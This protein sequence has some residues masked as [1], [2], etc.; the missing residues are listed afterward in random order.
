MRL[1][2]VY[3]RH[4]HR[5]PHQLSTVD[6]A[7]APSLDLFVLTIFLGSTFFKGRKLV[8][9]YP[10]WMGYF[11]PIYNSLEMLLRNPDGEVWNKSSFW[12]WSSWREE[13]RTKASQQDQLSN[14]N[15]S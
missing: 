1:L 6:R 3:L 7:M 12:P 13:E 2:S 9:L 11:L 5:T 15:I 4:G 10:L 14:S 8:F